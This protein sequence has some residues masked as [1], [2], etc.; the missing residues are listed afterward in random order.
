MKLS[1]NLSISNREEYVVAMPRLAES[2]LLSH[3]LSNNISYMQNKA[4]ET[5]CLAFSK[6]RVTNNNFNISLRI[7]F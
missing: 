6:E 3:F 5:M 4:N 2:F 1:V 7:L